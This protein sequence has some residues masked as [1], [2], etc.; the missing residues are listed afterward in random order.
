MTAVEDIHAHACRCG[1][2]HMANFGKM[3]ESNHYPG[4]LQCGRFVSQEQR[5][6][7]AHAHTCAFKRARHMHVH[8][9]AHT[10]TFRSKGSSQIRDTRASSD[11]QSRVNYDPI[12]C[13]YE[14][15]MLKFNNNGN[16]GV[17]SRSD[18][19]LCRQ[20]PPLTFGHLLSCQSQL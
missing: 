4:R 19:C 10:Y 15:G 6:H 1:N 5:A 8:T 20:G 3:L 14:S 7:T 18:A 16:T 13:Y 9:Q 2:V 11:R 12:G 17:C